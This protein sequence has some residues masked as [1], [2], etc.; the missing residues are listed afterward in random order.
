MVKN[1]FE[2]IKEIEDVNIQPK[3]KL[4]SLDDFCL[5]T[6]VLTRLSTKGNNDRW[7]QASKNTSLQWY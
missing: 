3:Q 7:D 2:F 4:I 6:N 1:S 5:F